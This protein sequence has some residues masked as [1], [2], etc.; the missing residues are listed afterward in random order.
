LQPI[1]AAE[2]IM[3]DRTKGWI[4][5]IAGMLIFSGS[6]PATRAAVMSLDPFFVTS[7]R[8]TLAACLG[9][10]MLLAV[11]APLP[12]RGDL[13]RLAI[14]AGGIVAGFPLLSGLALQHISAGRSVVFLGL[15][16]M[17]TALFGVAR[18]GERPP[19]PFWLF[20]VL[21]AGVIGAFALSRGGA[22][23]ARG[24]LL[25]LTAIIVCGLGYAEGAV[26]ARRLGGVQVICWA[27]VLSLPLALPA[28]LWC[29]PADLAPVT[30]LSWFGL[31][32]VTLFSMFI[33][34]VFWYR[35]LA[36]GGIAAISQLQLL[37]PLF[38]LGWSALLLHESVSWTMLEATAGIILCVAGARHFSQPPA[39]KLDKLTSS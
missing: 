30:P 2:V 38:G 5:G 9:A 26:L 25:M 1:K 4:N 12:D 39:R 22:S 23:S 24:D 11:R 13:K 10:A 27:L 28:A 18:G 35:G 32:Y 7:A 19:A 3:D 16:P 29:F 15:L 21:G 8:A 20:A 31:L 14:T 17:A 34:F 36:L 33:G 6:S 37:M